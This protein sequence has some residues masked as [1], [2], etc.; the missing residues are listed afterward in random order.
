MA[1]F[2]PNDYLFA[3]PQNDLKLDK[4]L[5]QNPGYPHP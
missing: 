3:I 2:T 5:T 1:H 4:L